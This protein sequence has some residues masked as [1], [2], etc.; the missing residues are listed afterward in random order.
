MNRYAAA[1]LVH[2][3]IVEENRQLSEIYDD[4]PEL[5][6]ALAILL[7]GFEYPDFAHLTLG[8]IRRRLLAGDEIDTNER[9]EKIKSILMQDLVGNYD[10]PSE[11][12]EWSWLWA[13]ASYLHKQNGVEGIQEVILNLANTLDN[14]P[15]S[16]APAITAAQQEGI[17]YLIFHQGT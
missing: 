13:N 11:V 2:T 16:L 7:P 15:A 9:F 10:V 5:Q 17:A 6:S 8:Q 14:I 1:V 3:L 12:P 4:E